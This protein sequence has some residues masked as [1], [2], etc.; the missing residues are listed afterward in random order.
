MV[1]D[2]RTALIVIALLALA[3]FVVAFALA[4]LV[5]QWLVVHAWWKKNVRTVGP[6]GQAT[7]LFAQLHKDKETNTPRGAGVI[8]WVS[9][10][11]VALLAR[12]A[13]TAA[14]YLGADPAIVS[15][16]ARFDF[17][18][19]SQTW[20]P[21]FV[22]VTVSLIGLLDDYLVV[23]G[24]G[25]IEKGGGIKFRHRILAVTLVA[26]VGAY[27]FHLKLGWDILH[28]PF[29]GDVFINGWYIPLFVLVLVALN[30]S[31]VVDG[32]DGLAGGIFA[33]L[34][35]MFAA[36]AFAR[37]QFFLSAFCAVLAGALVAFIWFNIP[38]ARFY[39]GETGIF[40]LTVTLGVVAFLTNTVLLLPIAGVVLVVEAGSVALQLFWKRVFKRKL[41]LIAPYHHHLEALGWPSHKVTMRLWLVTGIGCLLTLVLA[42]L[43]LVLK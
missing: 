21:L 31:S 43:D 8:F 23:G 42:T 6:D 41:F 5:G 24:F 20:I 15:S 11:I 14:A 27:W 12:F 1:M 38:P 34:F 13:H 2:P 10:I 40:G 39:M 19:R 36:I 17:I 33:M 37:G 9:V 25:V 35:A 4:P 32:I 28:V 30:A 7:T 3:G 29:V 22:I 26:L 16:L 18:N